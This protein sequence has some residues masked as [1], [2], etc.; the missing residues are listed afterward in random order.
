MLL[1]AQWN[2]NR[3]ETCCCLACSQSIGTIDGALPPIE[4]M[5]AIVVGCLV[6][7]A[8]YL[9]ASQCGS[10]SEVVAAVL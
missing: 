2:L 5:A 1:A 4:I 3:H 7:S 10:R 6:V 9:G 8:T